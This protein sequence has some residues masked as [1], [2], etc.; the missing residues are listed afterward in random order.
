MEK[1]F[2]RILRRKLPSQSFEERR[3]LKNII[4]SG[5]RLGVLTLVGRSLGLYLLEWGPGNLPYH[6]RYRTVGPCLDR[7]MQ[8]VELKFPELK[9][10]AF[11]TGSSTGCQPIKM[12]GPL[13]LTLVAFVF[14]K[15]KAK[16]SVVGGGG[17]SHN[18]SL[19]AVE[20]S[21]LFHEY[22]Y[23]HSL[24]AKKKET[25]GRSGTSYYL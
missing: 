14:Q 9:P 6:G 21:R 17:V 20:Y 18:S 12:G 1:L 3:K 15:G 24:Y 11:D 8:M 19:A 16:N 7:K 2:V 23:V 22:M 10:L 25:P 4:L 5:A 13:S